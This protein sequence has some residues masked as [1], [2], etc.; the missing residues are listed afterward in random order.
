[1]MRGLGARKKCDSA[2]Q[3]VV[4]ESCWCWSHKRIHLD[5]VI[6]WRHDLVTWDNI[7]FAGGQTEEGD[8]SEVAEVIVS[9]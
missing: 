3:A 2:V 4:V 7:A 5:F 1:M 8:G 9:G 6:T